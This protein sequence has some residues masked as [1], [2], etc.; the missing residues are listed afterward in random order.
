[1]NIASA[2]NQAAEVFSESGVADARREASS[3]LAFAINKDRTFLIAHPEHELSTSEFSVYLSY[4]NRRAQ[5]E[6]Y[7]YIV[8]RQEFFGLN[9]E[10]TSDVL[11]PRPET[12]ILVEKAIDI[13][14]DRP[15]PRFCEIGVGSGCISVSILYSVQRSTATAVDVSDR[16][17]AIARRNAEQN[18]VA[19]RLSLQMGDIFSDVAG[20]FDLVVS[21]PPYV[22]TCQIETLQAEVRMFEPLAALAGGTDGLNIIKRI[23][24]QSPGHLTSRGVLLMEIGFDQSERVRQ[25]FDGSIWEA[26]EFLADLQGIPRIVVAKLLK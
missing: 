12:E 17:N 8:G 9:F 20:R 5:H 23:V 18:G 15:D 11:V 25:L 21:N 26:P 22:P 4:I 1:M 10:V 13:L 7:Q 16:A 19:N 6:P 2:L 14:K 24:K 3:L